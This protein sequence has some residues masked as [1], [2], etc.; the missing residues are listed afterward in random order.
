MIVF[1]FVDR[2]M[3]SQ[4]TIHQ[5]VWFCKYRSLQQQ[6]PIPT[7]RYWFSVDIVMGN[8]VRLPLNIKKWSQQSVCYHKCHLWE[9]LFTYHTRPSPTHTLNKQ[10]YSIDYVINVWY[11]SSYRLTYDIRYWCVIKETR[12]WDKIVQVQVLLTVM[13]KLQNYWDKSDRSL[14]SSCFLWSGHLNKIWESG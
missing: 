13:L 8:I 10:T 9:S 7:W 2:P 1:L 6:L 12:C 5:D 11:W 3:Y 4:F 14:K